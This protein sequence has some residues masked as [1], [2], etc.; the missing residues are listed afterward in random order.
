MTEEEKTI[1]RLLELIN[2]QS[3]RAFAKKCDISETTVRNIKKGKVPGRASLEK[4]AGKNNTSVGW[5]LGE[6]TVTATDPEYSPIKLY[7]IG[8]VA[9]HEV[10]HAEN[11]TVLD[12]LAFRTAWIRN[13]LRVDPNQ[14][15][16]IFVTG[17]SMEPT[18]TAGD[19]ILVNHAAIDSVTDGVWVITMG[20]GPIVKRVERLSRN[21]LRI[22]SDNEKYKPRKIDLETPPDGMKFIGR[23]V[24][25]GKRM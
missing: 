3:N 9:G 7:D 10:A 4:I 22:I 6:A 15:S 13:E 17:D 20:D 24:W 21:E 16:M 18:L 23:V 11:E 1:G 12:V 19:M 8:A 2:A 14:L 25:S 5:L